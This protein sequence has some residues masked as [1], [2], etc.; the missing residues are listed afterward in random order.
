MVVALQ[1][2]MV[3]KQAGRGGLV[4]GIL[5]DTGIIV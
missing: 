5:V 4:P 1:E 3:W 2:G